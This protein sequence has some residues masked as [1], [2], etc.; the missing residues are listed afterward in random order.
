MHRLNKFKMNGRGSDNRPRSNATRIAE[1]NSRTSQKRYLFIY[2]HHTPVQHLFIHSQNANVRAF[3]KLVL[4]QN[5][6]YILRQFFAEG[7][8]KKVHHFFH[9]PPPKWIS[10]FMRHFAWYRSSFTEIQAL[11]RVKFLV[12]NCP[13]V[14]NI[15]ING[16]EF[17]I[18][19][20]VLK[21][22]LFKPTLIQEHSPRN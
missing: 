4:N 9:L 2:P 18:F 6:I 17:K 19:L 12:K 22:L 10:V 13:Q 11:E 1:M 5:V 21:Y 16:V 8:L 14:N 7:F 15:K 3:D 20:N